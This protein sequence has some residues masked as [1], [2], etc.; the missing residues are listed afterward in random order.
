MPTV[1]DFLHKFH[2]RGGHEVEFYLINQDVSSPAYYQYMNVDGWWYIVKA[3]VT[4]AVTAYTFTTPVS[5]S[6]ATGWTGRAALTYA[7][8][9]TAFAQSSYS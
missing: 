6:A 5:T 9:N 4:S 3:T 1:Q 2:G 7:A 8:F